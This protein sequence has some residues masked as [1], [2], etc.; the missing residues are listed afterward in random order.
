MTI[1]NDADCNLLLLGCFGHGLTITSFHLQ[2]ERQFLT[3]TIYEVL[4]IVDRETRVSALRCVL[5]G[6]Q[7]T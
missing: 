5:Q 7:I 3:R 4:G 2:Q 6:P 1:Y